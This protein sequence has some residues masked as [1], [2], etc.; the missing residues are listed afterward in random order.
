MY[1]NSRYDEKRFWTEWSQ[2]LYE[3]NVLL[4]SSRITQ[5]VGYKNQS[6]NVV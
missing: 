5:I 1:L 6:V 3:Y 2:V 4:N